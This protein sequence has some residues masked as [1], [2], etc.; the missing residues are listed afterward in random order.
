M[1]ESQEL[2]IEKKRYTKMGLIAILVLIFTIVFLNI[3]R[4]TMPWKYYTVYIQSKDIKGLQKGSPIFCNNAQVGSIQKIELKDNYILMT[5]TIS[6][7][8]K[9]PTNLTIRMKMDKIK[10]RELLTISV[11]TF[12]PPFLSPKDTIIMD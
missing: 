6:R 9:L 12:E 8:Y 1:K 11:G 5:S 2:I 10:K 7:K 4:E 3:T